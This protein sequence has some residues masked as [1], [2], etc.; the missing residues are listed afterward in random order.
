MI[1]S[2]MRVRL[3]LLPAWLLVACAPKPTP[4]EALALVREQRFANHGDR[5]T[6]KLSTGPAPIECGTCEEFA[7]KCVTLAKL[8]ELRVTQSRCEDG[9]TIVSLGPEGERLI[10]GSVLDSAD[11][12]YTVQIATLELGP[13]QEI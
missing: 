2:I 13:V 4:D 3:W 5:Y 7:G 9:R 10:A 1:P 8:V 11:G 6:W 12:T